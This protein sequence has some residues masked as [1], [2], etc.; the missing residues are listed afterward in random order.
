MLK[1]RVD[2]VIEDVASDNSYSRNNTVILFTDGRPENYLYRNRQGGRYKYTDKQEFWKSLAPIV[3]RRDLERMMYDPSLFRVHCAMLVTGTYFAN[4]FVNKICDTYEPVATEAEEYLRNAPIKVESCAAV[5][6]VSPSSLPSTSPTLMT[7][8]EPTTTPTTS[9][10][11]S[12][13]S[14][15]PAPTTTPSL[16]PSRTPSTLPTHSPTLSPTVSPTA[17]TVS[18]TINPTFDGSCVLDPVDTIEDFGRF[19]DPG[20]ESVVEPAQGVPFTV[21]CNLDDSLVAN[22]TSFDLGSIGLGEYYYNGVRVTSIPGSEFVSDGLGGYTLVGLSFLPDKDEHG[23]FLALHK[24]NTMRRDT[25]VG[26][27]STLAHPIEVCAIADIPEIY[28]DT[29]VTTYED[30]EAV[31]AIEAVVKDPDPSEVLTHLETTMLSPLAHFDSL[32]GENIESNPF[33]GE[34]T[35]GTSCSNIDLSLAGAEDFS[36][37]LELSVSVST[38][39]SGDSTVSSVIL[40]EDLQRCSIHAL[41][42]ALRCL[43]PLKLLSVYYLWRTTQSWFLLVAHDLWKTSV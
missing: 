33:L 16:S 42:K 3:K 5:P 39:Y 29:C 35:C 22:I 18:P 43:A 26:H 4:N 15:T 2:K 21:Q 10:T 34:T 1:Q 38:F 41:A 11:S 23:Y 12:P 19:T 8:S 27:T 36:G 40:R 17:P 9:P 28:A 24:L 7:S 14:P 20:N 32:N 13:A 37:F 6:S 30:V 25:G 31:L